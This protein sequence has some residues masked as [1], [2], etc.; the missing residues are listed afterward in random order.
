[1]SWTPLRSIIGSIM[2]IMS[3]I[4]I[5]LLLALGN[6][7][8]LGFIVVAQSLASG[9]LLRR[10]FLDGYHLARH[11]PHVVSAQTPVMVFEHQEAHR[12]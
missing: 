11:T 9:I 8:G 1:M 12:D 6:H 5:G 4:V 2:V 10:A 3:G 7:P